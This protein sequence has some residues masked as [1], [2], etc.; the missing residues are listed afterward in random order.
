MI[1]DKMTEAVNKQINAELYS[2]YLY[3][4]MS[5]YMSANGI[6]GAAQW[7]FA[8]AQEEMTHAWRL[9]G[10]VNSQGKHVELMA[11]D[12]PPT[13]FESLTHAMEETLTHEKKVTGLIND[14]AN[15]A[16]EEKDHASEIFLQ[17]FVSEQVEEEES[18]NEVLDQ[19][20]LMGD[21]GGGLFMIDKELG[22]RTFVMP[23]DLAAGG[24]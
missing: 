10:Y 19:L 21:Y 1:S 15:L 12:Q 14:L 16:R 4:S 7:F 22:A 11:I 3:L 13:Q 5:S 18:V 24:E 2:A 23:A 8:Q 20:K 6:K 17:W 9:Y